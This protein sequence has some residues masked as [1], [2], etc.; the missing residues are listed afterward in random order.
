M[1]KFSTQ[2]LQKVKQDLIRETGQ[3]FLLN[4]EDDN[5]REIL[6]PLVSINEYL[7]EAEEVCRFSG[8]I[9]FIRLLQENLYYED[10]L[11]SCIADEAL[12]DKI[13]S[14]DLDEVARLEEK[15]ETKS[16]FE[17][18]MENIDMDK[19]Y[20]GVSAMKNFDPIRRWNLK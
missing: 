18:I 10:N 1:I 8:C 2:E 4:S 15:A 12:V 9:H 5:I 19:Y 16:V 17:E 14:V 7:E 20:I 11:Y 3:I 13:L 6:T